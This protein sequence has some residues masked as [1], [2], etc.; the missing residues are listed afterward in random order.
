MT[1]S[2]NNEALDTLFRQARRGGP[3]GANGLPM[4]MVLA[5][6]AYD[7]L[8]YETMPVLFPHNLSAAI[9]K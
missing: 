5:I 6:V 2:L 1:Q 7:E 8:F 3:T 9:Q 4:R